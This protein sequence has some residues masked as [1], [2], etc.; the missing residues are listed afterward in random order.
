MK[1]IFENWQGKWPDAYV[2]K[3]L[4]DVGLK[5]PPFDE[6]VIAD[7]L[8]IKVIQYPDPT[9]E[10]V[11]Y[12]LNAALPWLLESGTFMK[13]EGD[14]RIIFTP[15]FV[16]PTKIRMNIFHECGHAILPW[17]DGQCYLCKEKDL[18]GKAQKL[19]ERE[20]FFCAASFLMPRGQ[21]TKNILDLNVTSFAAI[22]MLKERYY[23]SFEAAANWFVQNNPGIC[24]L[25]MIEPTSLDD[26]EMSE[27]EVIAEDQTSLKVGQ[28]DVFY[29]CEEPTESPLKVS[30]SI[31][32]RRFPDRIKRNLGIS[33]D[34]PFYTAWVSGKG[35]IGEI[36]AIELGLF[37]RAPL[38]YECRPI[39]FRQRLMILLWEED[40]QQFWIQPGPLAA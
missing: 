30:Y 14:K 11:P 6:L 35:I 36:S 34:S 24:A 10:P 26:P 39:G 21:F 25:V 27:V 16:A 7:S 40:K 4:K 15:A 2:I 22:Q 13:K 8:G 28:P 5:E 19:I 18:E 31:R 29:N 33:T 1:G 23:V 9:K 3:V 37:D 38:R 12:H 20:A 32:S 17:H